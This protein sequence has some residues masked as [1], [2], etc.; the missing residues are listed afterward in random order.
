M[1]VTANPAPETRPLVSIPDRFVW[2]TLAVLGVSRLVFH[3]FAGPL[4]DEAYYWLWGQHP[5]LSYFDH[6]PLQAW[7]QALSNAVFGDSPFALRVPSLVSTAWTAGMLIWWTRRARASF[8]E[9]RASAVIAAFFSV[10]LIFIYAMI[11]FNDHLMVALLMTSAAM[12]SVVFERVVEARTVALPALYGAA[13]ALGLAVITKHNAALFGIGV[14]AAVV[15]QPRLR[16]LLKSPHLY[17]AALLSVACLTPVLIWNLGHDGA[18]FQ[19]NLVDRFSASRP[20]TMR[21]EQL[22]VP[23]LL[24]LLTLSPFLMAGLVRALRS[25]WRDG[26]LESWRGLALATAIVPLAIL[27]VLSQFTAVLFYW[28]IVAW[29][30]VVPLAALAIRRMWVLKAHFFLGMVV[31]IAYSVNYAIF[32]LSALFGQADDE[33]AIVIGWPAAAAD[34][35]AARTRTEVDFLLATDYRVGSIMAFSTGDR[36]V[37]VI[38]ERNSQFDLWFNEAKRAG[39]DALIVSEPRFP[40]TELIRSRFGSVEAA[41]TVSVSR[42]GVTIREYQLHVGRGYIPRD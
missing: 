38:A 30:A 7:M 42:F 3:L 32:P 10:P 41:G 14:A 24:S 25:D 31:A 28:T 15:L 29:V 11:T 6:P 23:I 35:A 16:P 12:F 17:L 4:P 36:D 9:L 26:F 39:E 19:Y 18:S 2:I 13:L 22:I 5:D 8:P 37:E 40:L 21:L 33:T 20:L 34:V 27:L 1:T